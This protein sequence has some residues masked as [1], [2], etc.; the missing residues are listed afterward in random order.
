MIKHFANIIVGTSLA[1]TA[2]NQ[3]GTAFTG[4]LSGI[5]QA[6]QLTIGVGLFSH[7]S[8]PFKRLFK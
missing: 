7:A 8:K 2:M 6:T 3:V 1:G 5:G 4:S